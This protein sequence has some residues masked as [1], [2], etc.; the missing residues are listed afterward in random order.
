MPAQ[1]SVDQVA[2]RVGEP[3]TDEP[4][5]LLAEA[6]LD[7][8]SALVRFYAQQA[9]LAPA[10]APAVAVAISIAAAARAYQNPSGLDTERA[11]MFSIKR[12]DKFS[13]GCELTASE[14]AVLKQFSGGSGLFSAA[15]S[16]PDQIKPASG[17]VCTDRGY[18][19]VDWGGNKPFP[20]G[21]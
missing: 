15:L 6:C 11:D 3:I 7:E 20:L 10:L 5:V 17:G 4:D 9:W 16:N 13:M 21:W 12:D 8:A 18:A 2:A 19:P 14:I 1:G